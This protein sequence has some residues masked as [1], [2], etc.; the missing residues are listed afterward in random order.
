M[1]RKKKTEGERFFWDRTALLKQ[2]ADINIVISERDVGKSYQMMYMILSEYWKERKN[3]TPSSAIF[4]RRYAD[5]LKSAGVTTMHNCMLS[6][7]YGRNAV[8]EITGGEFDSIRYYRGEWTLIQVDSE[9]GLVKKDNQA[10]LTATA[11]NLCGRTKGA[12]FPNLKFIWFEEFV[13]VT[14]KSYL[15]REFALWSQ[16]LKT[17]IRGKDD[18][19][20]FLT[21]NR[22]DWDCPY[23][24][25]YG[26]QQ[27][28][29]LPMDTIRCYKIG[30]TGHVLAIENI[31]KPEKERVETYGNN[32]YWAFDN[33]EMNAI[34][35]EWD[36]DF[37]P[38]L[39]EV[40]DYKDVCGRF[41]VIYKGRTV[42]A[43][44]VNTDTGAFIYFHSDL[45]PLYPMDEEDDL[46]YTN[47]AS[48]RPNYRRGFSPAL[49]D[50]EDVIR[51][52][53]IAEKVFY[54]DNTTGDIISKFVRWSQKQKLGAIHS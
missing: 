14:G 26:I 5:D 29:K 28:D 46:I 32:F 21:G 20:L 35:G 52:L 53:M 34:N 49:S 44:I 25:N 2:N 7:F 17:F 1:P 33:P 18:V 43:D 41:F 50:G 39:S 12:Q 47:E 16:M 9:T 37:Y 15:P 13:E 3:G 19:K 6:D 36:V 4:V 31:R 45:D 8:K 24:E 30:R 54:S 23:F 38:T 40:Y 42:Q 51:S 48:I 11:V 10:F 27:A 22:I